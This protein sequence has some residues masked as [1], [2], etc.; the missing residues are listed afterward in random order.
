[1]AASPYQHSQGLFEIT[2]PKGWQLQEG[3]YSISMTTPDHNG[4]IYLEVINSGYPLDEQTFDQFIRAREQYLFSG[5]EKYEEESYDLDNVLQTAL[6]EKRLKKGGVLQSVTTFY[7]LNG[8]AV[9]ALDFW[10]ESEMKEIYRPLYRQVVDSL[11]LN[12]EAIAGVTPY[13]VRYTFTGPD[14]LFTLQ[15]PIHWDYQRETSDYAT[16]DT[17]SAPDNH[18]VIQSIVYNDGEQVSRSLAGAF[19]LDLLNNYYTRDVKVTQDILV[20][21]MERLTWHSPGGD[22]S[23]MTYFK[24][25]GN[26]ILVFTIM[27]DNPFRDLYYETLVDALPI[28]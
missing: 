17:F 28:S 13:A 21:D 25:E 3:D 12:P 11:H 6:V 23:G 19:A 24:I 1:L 4:L 2:P 18:A 14:G 20:G 5:Y 10:V 22:Y 7:S 16:V 27:Y 15:V 8:V 26:N 9:A